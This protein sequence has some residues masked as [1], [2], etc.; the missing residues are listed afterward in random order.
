MTPGSPEHVNR[1]LDSAQW[2]ST[3]ADRNYFHALVVEIA[4]LTRQGEQLEV[5]PIEAPFGWR[6]NFAL[7]QALRKRRPDKAA[8]AAAEEIGRAAVAHSR[9][10]NEFAADLQGLKEYRDRNRMLWSELAEYVGLQEGDLGDIERDETGEPINW[11][12][13]ARRVGYALSR[14]Q[15]MSQTERAEVPRKVEEKRLR[16]F[17]RAT[18]RRI[19]ALEQRVDGIVERLDRLEK[20]V[21][22]LRVAA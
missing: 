16:D 3:E 17:L 1:R 20:I 18:D 19:A 15:G 4:T 9:L 21:G 22:S 6:R 8:T 2:I 7:L 12:E 5:A 11:Q 10:M 14:L 13:R